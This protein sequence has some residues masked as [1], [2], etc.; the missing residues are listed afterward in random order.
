M[1]TTDPAILSVAPRVSI[2]HRPT[3]TSNAYVATVQHGGI[4]YTIEAEADRS[5]G[6]LVGLYVEPIP[7]FESIPTVVNKA[8]T[9]LYV[10]AVRAYSAGD[11]PT[12]RLLIGVSGSVSAYALGLQRALDD[13]A[14]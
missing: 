3:H 12:H 8:G 5:D 2:V 14:A 10:A 13:Q 6:K 9:A 11:L 4:A 1:T 7:P